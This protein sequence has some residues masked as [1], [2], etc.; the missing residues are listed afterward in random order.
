MTDR[1]P[2]EESARALRQRVLF[3]GIPVPRPP[4]RFFTALPNARRV[5]LA[6][7][8]KE[9]ARENDA[10]EAAGGEEHL[11][12]SSAPGMASNPSGIGNGSPEFLA[13]HPSS[14]TSARLALRCG[15]CVE[16]AG[17]QGSGKTTGL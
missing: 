5:A 9:A 17:T 10:A 16:L 2:R 4:E 14:A 11:P 1:A 13:A 3:G 6:L 15:M 8:E 7:K 12:A